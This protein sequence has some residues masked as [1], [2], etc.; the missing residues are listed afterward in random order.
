MPAI[1]NLMS[2]IFLL[3][4]PFSPSPSLPLPQLSPAWLS[5][6]WLGPAWLGLALLPPS[7]FP[8]K[9]GKYKFIFSD[10]GKNDEKK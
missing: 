1:C 7:S 3:L 10:L 9:T 4:P 2:D 5:L 8:P 6:T